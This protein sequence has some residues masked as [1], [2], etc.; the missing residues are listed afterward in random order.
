MQDHS[1]T[2]TQ[3]QP[4]VK[5]NVSSWMLVGSSVLWR[6]WHPKMSQIRRNS[7]CWWR[8]GG[9]LVESW[10]TRFDVQPKD[11]QSH[12]S[13]FWHCLYWNTS[14]HLANWRSARRQNLRTQVS[15]F[16]TADLKLCVLS[17]RL[18]NLLTVFNIFSSQYTISGF[19]RQPKVQLR[20]DS[21]AASSDFE[22]N[23]LSGDK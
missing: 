15:T 3:N 14:C 22:R 12:V 20:L 2:S 21:W 7:T 5:I 23:C 4:A 19:N 8:V 9:E 1:T 10:W 6:S 16:S 13:S 17:F 18:T 11:D